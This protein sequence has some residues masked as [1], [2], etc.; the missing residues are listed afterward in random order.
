MSF[1]RRSTLKAIILSGVVIIA[2]IT[3]GHFLLKKRYP[4][5]DLQ[6]WVDK[7][8]TRPSY[9]FL[10]THPWMDEHPTLYNNVTELDVTLPYGHEDIWDVWVLY[11]ASRISKSSEVFLLSTDLIEKSTNALR[12]TV[13]SILTGE[14]MSEDEYRELLRKY[15]EKDP[16][17]FELFSVYIDRKEIVVYLHITAQG[18]AACAITLEE[19]R[20][21]TETGFVIPVPA[22][23]YLLR[24]QSFEEAMTT[25]YIVTWNTILQTLMDQD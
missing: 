2:G 4:V 7:E 17:V 19:L 24:T 23:F 13:R 18:L 11:T 1:L 8:N 22:R 6:E 9:I 10:T 20:D 15:H 14:E 3:A 25:P 21:I 12:E 16:E 5:V